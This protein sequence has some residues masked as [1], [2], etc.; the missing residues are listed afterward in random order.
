M[1]AATA[2]LCPHHGEDR[3]AA[4]TLRTCWACRDRMAAHLEALPALY[5]RLGDALVSPVTG[6]GGPRVTG[7]SSAPL[8]INPAVADHRDQIRH[9]LVWWTKYVADARALALPDDRIGEIAGW[10]AAHVDWLAADPVA[11]EELPPV[12]RA[13]VG[14]A[15]GL[16]DPSRRLP[17][18]ERCRVVSDGAERCAGV[19]S[20]V[21]EADDT[22]TARC[23]VCGPQEAAPY[24]RNRTAGRWVTWER[25]QAY[26]LRRHR[27]RIG[28]DTVR[29]WARRGHITA[30]TEGGATWYDLGS[31]ERYLSRREKMAG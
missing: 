19:I 4:P 28:G 15:H 11:S 30:R 8:P 29:Q 13:L 14:R 27:V 18:G 20:M 7:T 2:L 24:L 21:Q 22:W 6:G 17:T 26:A 25:V 10:L 16:L 23:S 12:L 1:T 9:D 3:R 5:G 31:V